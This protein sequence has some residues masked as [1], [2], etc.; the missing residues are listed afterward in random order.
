MEIQWQKALDLLTSPS[1]SNDS[2]DENYKSTEKVRNVQR[3]LNIEYE[4]QTFNRHH[5]KKQPSASNSSEK[6]LDQ[7]YADK[8]NDYIDAVRKIVFISKY[9]HEIDFFLL[10]FT[11][12]EKI[13]S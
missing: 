13:T 12:A 4:T 1:N 6:I 7:S 9:V 11:V 2:K 3:N 10:L 5:H 8:L